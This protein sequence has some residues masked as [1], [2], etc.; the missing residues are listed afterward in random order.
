MTRA[1]FEKAW[2]KEQRRISK[3][4]KEYESKGYRFNWT[5]KPMPA[6]GIH[7][8]KLRELKETTKASLIR[9]SEYVSKQGVIVKG[10]KAYYYEQEA[11]AKAKARARA[12]A[13][14]IREHQDVADIRSIVESDLRTFLH[15]FIPAQIYLVR[16]RHLKELL[17]AKEDA[18]KT[19]LYLMDNQIAT[20]GESEFLARMETRATE[21]NQFK[22]DFYRDSTVDQVNGHASE[23]ATIIKGS[24]LTQ[25]ESEMTSQIEDI[26][27][28][29]DV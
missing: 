26:M 13:K 5:E 27:S 25:E 29:I 20:E 6:K 18:A 15:K 17:L 12:R 14:F 7:P 10:T 19:L 24:S 4:I 9:E 3:F 21:I 16:S 2:S 23:I 11:K 28:S 1:E 8:A 22:Y